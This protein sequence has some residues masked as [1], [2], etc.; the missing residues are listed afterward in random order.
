MTVQSQGSAPW[1]EVPLTPTRAG[2]LPPPQELTPG[3]W[4]AVDM[5]AGG[6]SG[7][8]SIPEDD[9][10][11]SE[12]GA[13]ASYRSPVRPTLCMFTSSFPALLSAC[14]SVWPLRGQLPVH[15]GDATCKCTFL[16]RRCCC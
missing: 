16:R 5:R 11:H 10:V 13:G 14:A 8:G 2:A 1:P 4:H 6:A 9:S 7:S 15:G 3:E 12:D